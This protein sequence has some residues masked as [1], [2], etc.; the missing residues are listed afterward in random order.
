MQLFWFSFMD[1]EYMEC[2]RQTW[3]TKKATEWLEADITGE[4]Q[5][6][7]ISC[8]MNKGTWSLKLSLREALVPNKTAAGLC[9]ILMDIQT[10]M[11]YFLFP[12]STWY[13]D[14][15]EFYVR[16]EMENESWSGKMFTNFWTILPYLWLDS[17]IIFYIK[18]VSKINFPN[19]KMPP[20]P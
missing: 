11:Q 8:K 3:G 20:S 10:I 16:S 4:L 6:I 9:F 18:F 2:A 12:S 14:T 17:W 1:V 19:S 5:F 13:P 7:R 15:F